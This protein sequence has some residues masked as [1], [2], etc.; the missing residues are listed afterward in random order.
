[1]IDAD[2]QKKSGDIQRLGEWLDKA[3]K[4]SKNCKDRADKTKKYIGKTEQLAVDSSIGDMQQ[5]IDTMRDLH[6]Q[7]VDLLASLGIAADKQIDK[8]PER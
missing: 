7:A 4:I 3:S 6:S 8:Q 2:L 1:M 5:Q